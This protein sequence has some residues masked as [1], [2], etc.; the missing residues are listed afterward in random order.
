ML[1]YD[2]CITE[3]RLSV[4]VLASFS[5]YSN[6]IKLF[7]TSQGNDQLKCLDAIRFLSLGNSPFFILFNYGQE[8]VIFLSD[9]CFI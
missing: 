6:T 8:K 5:V 2:F 1:A 9:F 7:Q 3:E 4:R